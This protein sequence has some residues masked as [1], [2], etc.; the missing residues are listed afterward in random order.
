MFG[1]IG[2][3]ED[4]VDRDTVEWERI[5]RAVAFRKPGGDEI[6][7]ARR[8]A[9][10]SCKKPYALRLANADVVSYARRHAQCKAVEREEE[11]LSDGDN[12]E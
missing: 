2:M 6:L 8:V 1:G 12:A 10:H 7:I 4:V 11:G 5:E 3:P 9:C